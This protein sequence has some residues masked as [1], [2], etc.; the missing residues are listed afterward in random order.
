MIDW[1]AHILPGVDDG[2]RDIEESV[3]MVNMEM[4]Q[5]IDTIIATPH[6]YADDETVESF[7]A[8]RGKALELL[9]SE[10]PAD[11]PRIIPGAEVRYYQGISRMEDLKSLRIEGSNILLLEM[12]MDIWTERMIRELIEIS[13]K[14]S[15]QLV[16]AHVERYL[17]LQKKGVYDRLLGNDILM[18]S[19]ASFFTSFSSRR[20]ALSFLKD[21]IVHFIGSDCHNLTS[22]PP[23][24][25]DAVGIIKKKLGEDYIYRINEYGHSLLY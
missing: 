23:S 4:S 25:G 24:V 14:G 18:Q 19:N 20:K 17:G 13:A 8:R 21:G 15:I 10:L 1:H 9:K 11:A 22:R 7:L 5:G 3:S 16:L 6:F 12:P 2:S